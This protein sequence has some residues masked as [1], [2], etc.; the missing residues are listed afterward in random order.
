VTTAHAVV[1]ILFVLAYGG[2]VVFGGV[3][4]NVM[5]T[6]RLIRFGDHGGL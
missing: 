2:A 6:L 3:M 4:A 1:T 5:S